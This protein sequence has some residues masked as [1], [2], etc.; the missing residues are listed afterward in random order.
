[1]GNEETLSLGF[2]SEDCLRKWAPVGSV[3][4]L[5]KVER[6]TDF[7]LGLNAG[8][9]LQIRM[10]QICEESTLSAKPSR[11]KMSNADDL[12]LFFTGT[13]LRLDEQLEPPPPDAAYLFNH[14]GWSGNAG[15]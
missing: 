12:R 3:V 5:V 10:R 6:V 8:R 14:Y 11:L 4:E 2:L 7:H 1:M 9:W 15:V 13:G